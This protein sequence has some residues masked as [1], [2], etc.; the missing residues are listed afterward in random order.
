M[1]NTFLE[2]KLPY[3][4]ESNQHSY[5]DLLEFLFLYLSW[6]LIFFFYFISFFGL[7]IK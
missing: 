7:S 4:E 3:A 6:S 1:Y 5:L 2:N